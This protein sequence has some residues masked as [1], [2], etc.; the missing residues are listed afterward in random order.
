MSSSLSG[1]ED[2]SAW[3]I[4][5]LNIILRPLKQNLE[6]ERRFSELMRRHGWE[7]PSNVQE[8]L[9]SFPINEFKELDE[10]SEQIVNADT[11]NIMEIYAQVSSTLK[12]IITKVRDL[13][14][15]SPPLAG[16]VPFNVDD[17][18]SEFP[19]ELVHELI[20]NY[21]KTSHPSRIRTNAFPRNNRREFSSS[22]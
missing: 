7:P 12:N 1:A 3:L 20:I 15:Q 5:Q 13:V 6:D 22:E 18:W 21:L 9:A 17:F 19:E 2:F 16:T 8:M 4:E 11:E 14:N 10:L